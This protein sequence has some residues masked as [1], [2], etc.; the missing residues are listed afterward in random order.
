MTSTRRPARRP[1]AR[2]RARAAA[3]LAVLTAPLLALGAG[4]TPARAA[5]T[6]RTVQVP[7]YYQQLGNDCEAA[8]LRMMLAA[9]GIAVQDQQI[10]DRIGVDRVH[11][12]FGHDGPNSGDPF[13]AF[14]G[15]PDGSE[16][17]GTG[18]GVYDPPVA[19]AARAYGAKVA[20]TGQGLTPA[21]LR[22]HVQA[23]RPAIVWV[24]YLWRKRPDHPYTAYD[25]RSVLYAG[26]AEHA[27]V[28]TGYTDLAVTIN[29]PAR[30]HLTV[31]R[32]DFE[33]GY[34]TYGDMAVVLEA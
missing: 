33:A 14:V 32:G 21:R 2:A 7:L 13:K 24:D 26:P 11:G 6:T 17:E 34:A 29:D 27:V 9:H 31:A 30:G 12:E 19:A 15:D 28:V 4:T 22:A 5:G 25:G 8:A 16:N 3:C 1:R 23:G 10:L 18:Y 20:F